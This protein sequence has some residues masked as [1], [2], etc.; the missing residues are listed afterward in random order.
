MESE[1]YVTAIAIKYQI[2]CDKNVRNWIRKYTNGE[3]AKAHYPNSKVY[4]IKSRKTS[5]KERILIV[6]DCFQ[7]QLNYKQTAQKF[8]VFYNL[9][10]Q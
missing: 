4:N 10:F 5:L 1:A 8:Y 3:A 7:N 9:V 2:P 6:K